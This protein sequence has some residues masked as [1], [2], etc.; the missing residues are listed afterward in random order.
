MNRVYIYAYLHC[1]VGDDLF[2]KFLIEK[3]P[4]TKFYVKA[5]KR[6][7]KIFK[8][9]KNLRI[10]VDTKSKSRIINKIKGRYLYYIKKNCRYIIFIGGSI[11]MEYPEWKNIIS[12]YKEMSKNKHSYVIGANFGPYKSED[13]YLQLK[14]YFNTLEDVCFRDKWSYGLFSD[15]KNVRYAPDI[16]FAYD[17]SKYIKNRNEKKVLISVIDCSSRINEPDKLVDFFEEYIELISSIINIL[18]KKGFKI[19]L[20]S[21][22]KDEGDEKAIE[23][24]LYKVNMEQ[25]TK[26]LKLYY[27]GLNLD[28]M[29]NEMSSS[30]YVIGTRF[31]SIILSSLLKKPIL[32]IVYSNKTKN[33]LNDANFK[34]NIIY[35]RETKK[36][37][38][39]NILN[40]YVNNVYLDS[41]LYHEKSK[42]QFKIIDKIFR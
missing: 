19:T 37:D 23:D 29:L 22:C 14:K 5:D 26:I 7:K 25:K 28:E 32:P 30:C 18:S 42:D 17:I 10:V 31:H 15:C 39:S 9:N 8:N 27:N 1:N 2:V 41:G 40:N 12:W 11:F 38:I 3:Y 6:Y 16:L 20:A 13:Y 34:G 4:N 36:Y 21:F 24:I 33:F 35:I